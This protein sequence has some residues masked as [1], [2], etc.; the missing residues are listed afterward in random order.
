MGGDGFRRRGSFWT[1]AVRV[2]G[3]PARH[4]GAGRVSNQT[5]RSMV[6]TRL[7]RPS[8]ASARACPGVP[9]AAS[10]LGWANGADDEPEAALLHGED[11][12]DPSA[13]LGPLGVA[14][15]DVGRHRLAPGLRPLQALDQPA[16]GEHRQVVLGTVG[17]VRPHAARRVVGVEY[18][19]ELGRGM[20]HGVAADEAVPAVDPGVPER[21]AARG[22][23]DVGLVAERRDHQFGRHPLVGLGRAL[24]AALQR[25]AA[26][27]VDLRRLRLRPPFRRAAAFDGG[28]LV[29]LQPRPPGLHH[30]RV[31]DLTAHRQV[32]G[33]AQQP[34]EPLEQ[35]RDGTRLGQLFA[36]QPQGLGVRH[37][38]AEA[39]PD[40]A[41]E[42]QPVAR[43][44]LGLIVRQRVERLRH[45]QPERQHRV[46]GRPAALGPVRAPRGPLQP[47]DVEVTQLHRHAP[48]RSPPPSTHANG[49]RSRGCSRRPRHRKQL[50]CGGP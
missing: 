29:A 6:V 43:L 49:R 33:I 3:S 42:R 47:V 25:P 30:R 1:G 20:G 22:G 11:V 24:P 12:L 16:P 48:S 10:R 46:V 2:L 44:V 13:D 19:R 15:A 9:Q 38:V 45:Q 8:L 40:E 32:T 28:L 17:R 14:A 31:D 27:P 34:V 36:E 37:R 5:R 39:E 18:G 4:A 41:H 50:G 21:R 26:V 23:G 7:A 35:G